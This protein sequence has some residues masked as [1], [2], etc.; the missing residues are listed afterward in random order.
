MK[1][2]VPQTTHTNTSSEN[3]MKTAV[4]QITHTNTSSANA[5]IT[6]VPQI[7]HRDTSWANAMITA[8]PQITHT[9]TSSANAMITAVPQITHADTSWAN[10]M[11]TA[12]SRVNLTHFRD[13]ARSIRYWESLSDF[14]QTVANGCGGLRTQTQ[15]ST[16]TALPPDP[17]SET[18]TQPLRI[19]EISMWAFW[20]QWAFRS[21]LCIWCG[22]LL[23]KAKHF[24]FSWL[25][26]WFS[27][28]MTRKCSHTSFHWMFD[29]LLDHLTFASNLTK[30]SREP[31]VKRASGT[32]ESKDL[33]MSP[34]KPLQPEKKDSLSA[35]FH[36]RMTELARTG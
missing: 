6:A 5:M 25:D 7:T 3:A 14:R 27:V 34:T 1:A 24:F 2:A 10:A 18:G 20:R 29:M 4:P 32:Q 8:V 21:S 30:K 28:P 13:H 31:C 9:N 23:S 22:R 16:N 11:I 36:G 17:Q 12:A 15:H 26:V 35:S 33:Y 19:R